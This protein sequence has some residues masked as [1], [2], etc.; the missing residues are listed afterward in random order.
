MCAATSRAAARSGESSVPTAKVCS[1][2]PLRE[3]PCGDRRDEARVQAAGEE[4]ADGHVAHELALHGGDQ[5][6]AGPAQPLLGR[7]RLEQVLRDRAGEA[8][9]PAARRPRAARRERLDVGLPVGIER[10]HLAGEAHRA[11]PSRPVQGFDPDRVACGDE[12]AVVGRGDH[13]VHPVEPGERLG[14]VCVEQQQRDLVVGVG[15]RLRAAE[16]GAHVL[17]VVDLAVADEPEPALGVLERLLAVL[18]VDDRQPPMAKPGVADLDR[19]G[20]VGP[21]VGDTLEHP[22]ERGRVSAS[23]RGHDAAHEDRST[24]RT[25]ADARTRPPVVR[26]RP[27]GGRPGGR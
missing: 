6:V 23:V 13:R 14:P 3:H 26:R 7:R 17:V 9:E 10:V 5:R 27:G 19:S 25:A 24:R 4:R 8:H 22:L 18:E 16:P 2:S 12:A 11:V 1:R 15:Q 21:A 20:V